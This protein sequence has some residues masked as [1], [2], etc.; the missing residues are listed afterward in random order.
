MLDARVRPLI[1][2]VL[3]ATGGWLA[4]RGVTANALTFFSLITGLA[5]GALIAV[6]LLHLALALLLASRAFDGLDGAVARASAPTDLG[7][8]FDSVADYGFYAAIPLG[9]ALLDPAGNALA[10]AALL[11]SFL[12]TCSSFLAFAALAGRR[13]VRTERRGRKS[14]F[15]S[16]GLVEGTETIAMFVAMLLWPTQ[17]P[18]I[19][20][21]FGG[22]CVVTALQRTRLARALLAHSAAADQASSHQP[23]G[24]QQ[25]GD[26]RQ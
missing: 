14:F 9:F 4:R 21:V 20:W 23:S 1:D 24:D 8:Y 13:G 15:Y 25:Q 5:A 3:N 2:P 12:L 26:A 18:L 16:G 11:A 19:A 10:A 17:F 7:G 6:G 22:L